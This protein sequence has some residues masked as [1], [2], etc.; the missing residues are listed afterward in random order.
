MFHLYQYNH[1]I[2]AIVY[3][4]VWRFY[5]LIV[6]MWQR[7]DSF[8]VSSLVRDKSVVT[9]WTECNKVVSS[10]PSYFFHR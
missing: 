10:N 9:E 5:T 7:F 6:L 4:L 2:S 3:Q 1:V 8:L